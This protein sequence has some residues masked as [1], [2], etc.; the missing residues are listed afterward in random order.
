MPQRICCIRKT[1]ECNCILLFLSYWAEKS[2][3]RFLKTTQLL[4]AYFKSNGQLISFLIPRQFLQIYRCQYEGYI[5]RV[6]KL[7]LL[8]CS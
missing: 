2:N 4:S 1:Y 5:D 7:A 6:A 3:F 8:V